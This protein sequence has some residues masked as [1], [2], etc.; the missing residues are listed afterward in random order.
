MLSLLI[1]DDQLPSY[2]E[3][4]QHE[5]YTRIM[6]SS[7]SKGEI[8]AKLGSIFRIL[9]VRPRNTEETFFRLANDFERYLLRL[10]GDDYRDLDAIEYETEGNS[11]WFVGQ[12]GGVRRMVVSVE[13]HSFVSAHLTLRATKGNVD[14]ADID[15]GDTGP[16]IGNKL[17]VMRMLHVGICS[18]RALGF[19]RLTNDPWDDRLRTLYASFGFQNGEVLDLN[20]P[21]ALTSALTI[22]S[23]VYPRFGIDF[24]APPP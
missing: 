8:S 5:E 2:L 13:I 23:Q 18:F 16:D 4:L 7:V 6:S 22:I 14:I 15:W 11:A 3:T 21:A 19:Q 1:V 20:D 10:T 9:T 24:S 17:L 12:G